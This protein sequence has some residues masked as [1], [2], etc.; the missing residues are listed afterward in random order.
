MGALN[1]L[2]LGAR[3]ETV[4]VR[5]RLSGR[6]VIAS[7][8]ITLAALSFVSPGGKG[9]AA[10][11]YP[12]QARREA[13]LGKPALSCDGDVAQQMVQEAY[14]HTLLRH[15]GGWAYQFFQD[16]SYSLRDIRMTYDNT[17]AHSVTCV[18]KLHTDVSFLTSWRLPSPPLW[19]QDDLMS[20]TLSVTIDG[21]FYGELVKG[22]ESEDLHLPAG[23]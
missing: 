18:A 7:L 14:R 2:T 13:Q 9:A 19:Q 1:K 6:H 8:A 17:T 23:L 3:Q 11:A 4:W 10:A 21:Q 22:G 20:Y 15:S 16:A 5:D 12:E